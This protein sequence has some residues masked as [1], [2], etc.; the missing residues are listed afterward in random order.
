MKTLIAGT[1]I[2]ILTSL[3]ICYTD[4]K[5][6]FV[7]LFLAISLFLMLNGYLSLM[8]ELVKKEENENKKAD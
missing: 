1:V 4:E 7:L 2:L 3:W 5:S 6:P 8:H